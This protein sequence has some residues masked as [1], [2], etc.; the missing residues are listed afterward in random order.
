MELRGTVA[1]SNSQEWNYVN[2][3]WVGFMLRVEGE[4]IDIL[5]LSETLQYITTQRG[6][7]QPVSHMD[8]KPYQTGRK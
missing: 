4:G 1:P 3:K 5:H 8:T 7:G 6:T 2:F